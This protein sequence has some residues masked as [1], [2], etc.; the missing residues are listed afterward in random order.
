MLN[1][2]AW[3]LLGIQEAITAIATN[4]VNY[5]IESIEYIL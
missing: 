2:F 4:N 1:R 5:H 3:H